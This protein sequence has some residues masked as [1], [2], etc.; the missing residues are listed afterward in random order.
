MLLNSFAEKHQ[1]SPIHKTENE[2]AIEF[3]TDL[4]AIK[5][6]KYRR[7]V[8]VTLHKIGYPNLEINLFNLLNYL[9]ISSE[10]NYF[11]EEK[12][13]D[14]CYKNQINYITSIFEQNY[15]TIYNF[16]KAENYAESYRKL[17]EYLIQRYPELFKKA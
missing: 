9:G 2:Q 16:F 8:Y 17:N 10:A 13:P 15:P 5:F 4:F 3:T 11:I 12:N 1:F 14:E 7:G 6:E